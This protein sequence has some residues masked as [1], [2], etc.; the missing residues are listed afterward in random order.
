MSRDSLSLNKLTH[1]EK[2]IW[3]RL[4]AKMDLQVHIGD[5]YSSCRTEPC[6]VT[7]KFE[8]CLLWSQFLQTYLLVRIKWK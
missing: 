5:E 4:P 7:C 1:W 6:A 8:N 3:A 2:T